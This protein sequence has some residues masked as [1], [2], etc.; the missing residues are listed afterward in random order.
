MLKHESHFGC[1]L[2][3][4]FEMLLT[5]PCLNTCPQLIILFKAVVEHLERW[6]LEAYS[7]ALLSAPLI[8]GTLRYDL[9]VATK[10]AAL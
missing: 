7:V 1:L 6:S 5:C 10:P 9:L 3:F 4:D 2:L 8:P